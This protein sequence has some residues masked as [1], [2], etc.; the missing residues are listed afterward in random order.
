MA[1]WRG[2]GGYLPPFQCIP[3]PRCPR[4]GTARRGR[5]WNGV[6]SD[7]GMSP[8]G[9]SI[10]GG[11]DLIKKQT[12]RGGGRRG[13]GCPCRALRRA[14]AATAP[15]PWVTGRRME[16]PVA[17]RKWTQPLPWRRPR[18]GGGVNDH[19]VPRPRP[20]GGPGRAGAGH[21]GPAPPPPN[22]RVKANK[23]AEQIGGPIFSTKKLPTDTVVQ[24]CGSTPPPPQ[25]GNH[26]FMTSPPPPRGGE[27]ASQ[28]GRLEGGGVLPK[29][30]SAMWQGLC[31]HGTSG[32]AQG[33]DGAA[34]SAEGAPRSLA[35]GPGRGEWGRG[36]GMC[37]VRMGGSRG[38]HP[39]RSARPT[40]TCA[41]PHRRPVGL[42][43]PPA[44]TAL[45]LCRG[46]TR[47][48]RRQSGTNRRCL[49]W[50]SHGE[51]AGTGPFT[52]TPPPPSL[53]G[54]GWEVVREWEGVGV[55]RCY[56]PPV[57]AARRPERSSLP[58]VRRSCPMCHLVSRAF[59]AQRGRGA[60]QS[61]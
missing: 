5:T 54:F 10:A 11:C 50:C 18:Q 53:L 43:P 6:A 22:R 7:A 49:R 41:Y 8:G 4:H 46:C 23:S 38:P 19:P 24:F 36:Q 3:P 30:G 25:G 35:G 13:G 56:A 40:G 60:W 28:G 37:G 44:Q 32:G 20:H 17:D 59:P 26:H 14:S 48:S 31:G 55:C 33:G 27:P 51:G 1:P 42:T 16:A 57:G 9:H 45:T 12:S 52:P 34:V 29:L 47:E 39:G 2:G 58:H 15:G 61:M 21:R